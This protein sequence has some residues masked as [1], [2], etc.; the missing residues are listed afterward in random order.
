MYSFSVTQVLKVAVREQR[1]E[2][3]DQ[4]DSFPSGHSTMAFAFGGYIFEEHG[5]KWGVPALAASVFT[6]LSRIND[7]RHYLHDVMAGATIGLAY[8]V[9]MSKLAKKKGKFAYTLVP[10][11]DS[12]SKGIAFIKDF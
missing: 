4:R 2:N 11:L 8:G 5:W 1:P 10:I 9:G 7:N 3:K 12:Q 6:A